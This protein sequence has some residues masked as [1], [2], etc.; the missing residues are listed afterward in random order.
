[1]PEIGEHGAARHRKGEEPGGRGKSGVGRSVMVKDDLS[2]DRDGVTWQG[3]T[4]RR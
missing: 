1:M 3:R 2:R 4:G